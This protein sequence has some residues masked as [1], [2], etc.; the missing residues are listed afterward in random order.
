VE[1]AGCIAIYGDTDSIFAQRTEKCTEELWNR[2]I[3]PM[4][5]DSKLGGFK[6]E[7]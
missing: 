7:M 5:D 3:A 6:L 4:L 1:K 2:Y